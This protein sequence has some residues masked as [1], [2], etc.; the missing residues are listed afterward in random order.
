MVVGAEDGH[1]WM[2]CRLGRYVTLDFFWF[3]A[4]KDDD[5]EVS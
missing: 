4:G 3:P 5:D 1:V 2:S